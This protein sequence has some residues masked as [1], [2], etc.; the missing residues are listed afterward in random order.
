[1]DT[2]ICDFVKQYA[3][4][5]DLRLHM[6]GHKGVGAAKT[7]G[8]DI[9]EVDGADVLY[10]ADGIIAQSQKNAGELF[11]SGKTLYSAEGSSLCIRAMVYLA[12]LYARANHKKPLILA[13]RNAHKTFLSALFL[14]GADVEWVYPKDGGLVSCAVD[15]EEL[16][17][18]L[19]A[20][21]EK[22]VAFYLTSPDYLGVVADVAAIAK[23][24]KKHGV[25]LLVDNAHGAYLKFLPQ[26]L[27]PLALGADMCADSAHKTLPVL[28]GGAY[29]H[30]SKTA[31]K[32]FFELAEHA[33]STFASTSPSYLILQSLDR[34]NAYLFDGYKQKLAAFVGELDKLKGRL[35][36]L[37]LTICGNEPLKVSVFAK[38][39][40]YFGFEMAQY[41]QNRHIRC[42]F[43]DRDFLVMM[44]T[45]EIGQNGLEQVWNAFST[46]PKKAPILERAPAVS[47]KRRVLSVAQALGALSKEVLAKDALSK[48]L[49]S[50]A[51]SCPPAIPIAVSG[52]LIDEGAVKLFE[53]YG[54]QTCRV[55]VEE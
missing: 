30:L 48:V 12:C 24:C 42:E 45:P 26:N 27:H 6:P 8:L 54:V 10:A 35:V 19:S 1:M 34:A 51:A 11:E 38:D 18:R 47:K 39:Y 2:P 16:D 23:T 41:L 50:A 21:R 25:L 22:P 7:E 29:L 17:L 4:A 44:F 33:L 28:T 32:L 31:P 15:A 9:T 36:S 3:A 20:M 13:A 55:V 14:T 43:S 37:G 5:G 49:F 53:Y 40:G 52:E 46:L